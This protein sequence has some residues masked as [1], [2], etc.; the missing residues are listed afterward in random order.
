MIGIFKE[1]E[2][3]YIG[4]YEA[5]PGGYVFNHFKGRDPGYNKIHAATCRTLWRKKDLGARTR[6]EKICSDNLKELIEMTD[7]IRREKGYTL[8]KICI[9]EKK[10]NSFFK[11]SNYLCNYNK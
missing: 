10:L 7:L 6:V 11:H 4:W 5:N 2:E 1:N 3:R 9:D 8:C